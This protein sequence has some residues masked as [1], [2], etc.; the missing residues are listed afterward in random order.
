MMQ[1]PANAEPEALRILRTL[2]AVDETDGGWRRRARAI[3][4][5]RQLLRAV[6]YADQP[7]TGRALSTITR[8]QLREIAALAG[9]GIRQ[10]DI[11]R[12][13]GIRAANVQHHLQPSKSMIAAM[14]SA[15]DAA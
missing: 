4:Q 1:R 2:L 12:R 5:G 8:P 15:E 3:V 11:A 7:H 10:S 9:Q 13:M 6:D 14:M